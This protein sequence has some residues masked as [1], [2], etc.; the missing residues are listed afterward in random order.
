VSSPFGKKFEKI[1]R[2]DKMSVFS[3][4]LSAARQKKSLTQR[5]VAEAVGMIEQ[6]YQK[7]EYGTREPDLKRLT[8]LS[9][10]LDVST[11]YLLGLK[12]EEK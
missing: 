9:K 11:E 6:A 1:F 8:A 7:Y 3:Q 4:R 10:L 5:Q 2:G 12:D